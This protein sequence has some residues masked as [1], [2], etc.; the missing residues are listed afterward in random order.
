MSSGFKPKGLEHWISTL[1]E[2]L[3]PVLPASAR[4]IGRL[5]KDPD[6]SLHAIGDVIARDPVMRVH[7]VRECNRQ[8]GERA[9]GTLANPHHCA[10]MMGLDKLT[11]LVRQFKA[12]KGDPNDPRDYH[13]FQAISTSLHA[14]E[15][16]AS[17]A[18]YRNQSSPD[19]MFLAAL[20]YGVPNWALWRLAHKEMQI[21]DTLFRREQIPLREA[22]QAVLGCT[23]EAIALELARRWHMPTAIQDALTSDQLPTP[24]FLL[25]AA[26]RHQR[27]PHYAMPNRTAE[28][29]LVNTPALATALSNFLAQESARDW[30]SPQTRRC[31]DIV[32][33]YLEQP[34]EPAEALAKEVAISCSRRWR[35]PGIQAPANG[36]LW[37][38][39]PRRP[40]SLKP[41]HIPAAVAKLYGQSAAPIAPLKAAAPAKPTAKPIG[42]R[43]EHLPE[44]L[45][46]QSI[47]NA[48]R[49]MAATSA[50]APH[51]GFISLEKKR[52]F[53]AL[54]K[55]LL[56]EPDYFPTE[57]EAVRCVVD[58]LAD[59]TNLQRVL[60][61]N[62]N[63][64]NHSADT[65]YARG[66]E[67]APLL[68][69][70][71]VRLQPSNLFSQLLKQPAATWIS[72]DRPSAISGL[73]P[74]TFKQAAQSD[75]FF[76]M[77]IFNHKGAYGLFYADKGLNDRIGLS[78]AEYKVFKVACSTCS[79]HLIT[80]G[81]RAAA[82]RANQ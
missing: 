34:R 6:A 2:H 47:L 38:L 15:Q 40:R 77:S 52:E 19:A 51:P 35:L 32:A 66:C 55:K 41:A 64:A 70:C 50:P 9:A 42:M 24:R 67:D 18:Q 17:W 82:K 72:P 60:I 48:P 7:V 49:P 16:A 73:V 28:G 25:R 44:D 39:Q 46:R 29:Q 45:D 68:R 63:R 69:K 27:D 53:E 80:R 74:G 5:L 12:T 11:I 3:L 8:F 36:L 56:Q 13:Y 37:P 65:Y 75:T 14:A 21:I 31:L 43:S 10:S 23:R 30:Y 62:Y 58:V 33:A 79:K 22:E 78:E 54:M 26:H 81:K 76:V 59:T 20:L 1:D 61:S 57:Y 4:Q 71:S